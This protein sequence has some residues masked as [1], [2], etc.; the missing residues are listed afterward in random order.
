MCVR[1]E[2]RSKISFFFS[3]NWGCQDSATCNKRWSLESRKR[4]TIYILLNIYNMCAIFC[5]EILYTVVI[6]ECDADCSWK[7]LY[8][9]IK[10]KPLVSSLKKRVVI[11]LVI[12]NKFIDHLGKCMSWSILRVHEWEL[13]RLWPLS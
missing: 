13:S 6:H 4:K 7:I 10:K 5:L 11:Y 9:N 12:G 1:R 3:F 8:L 2:R